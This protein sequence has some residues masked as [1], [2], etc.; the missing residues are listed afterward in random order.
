MNGLYRLPELGPDALQQ[1]LASVQD[2]AILCLASM[3]RMRDHATGNHILRT[4]HYVRILALH[5][6]DHPGFSD[7]LDDDLTLELLCRTATL[8]DIGK[9]AI[10][11]RILLKP[12]RLTA[13]EFEQMKLHTVYGHQALQNV[14]ALTA[15]TLGHHSR[16]FLRIAREITLSHH[17]RWDGQG[18]PQGLAGD[19]IPCT[20]RIMALADVYD[21]LISRRPYKDEMSHERATACILE[22]RGSH[23]DPAVVDAFDARQEEFAAIAR[24]MEVQYPHPLAPEPS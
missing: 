1:E 18:Y 9:V 10:P 21:A 12:G 6:R 23:F 13:A 16:L 20:A 17:E 15:V 4:Q 11:D 5:L 7:P 14:E 19:E 3:A 8:H 22:G 2:T 24:Q